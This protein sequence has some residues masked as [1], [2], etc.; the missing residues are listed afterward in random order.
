[1][2]AKKHKIDALDDERDTEVDVDTLNVRIV[3]WLF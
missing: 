1:M 3:G 2:F